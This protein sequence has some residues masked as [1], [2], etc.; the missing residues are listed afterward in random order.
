M[1]HSD[2][3]K[4]SEIEGSI[5]SSPSADTDSHFNPRSPH[6]SRARFIL[7]VI[8]IAIPSSIIKELPLSQFAGVSSCSR[9]LNYKAKYSTLISSD[10]QRSH[11]TSQF[12]KAAELFSQAL[13]K[14]AT[15]RYCC[16]GK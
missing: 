15:V 11:A 2:I 12:G 3:G 4:L 14:A 1:A 5:G 7:D 13:N 8:D 10:G 6:K 9:A 16:L